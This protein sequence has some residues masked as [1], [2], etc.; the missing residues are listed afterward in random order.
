MPDARTKQNISQNPFSK[1][2]QLHAR[3]NAMQVAFFLAG[4]ITQVKESIPWVRC[5]SGNVFKTP[6][7]V[8]DIFKIVGPSPLRSWM[9]QD[10]C[11]PNSCF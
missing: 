5:A 11:R 3:C 10:R 2:F 4:E 7:E 8:S 1:T 9:I 6:V